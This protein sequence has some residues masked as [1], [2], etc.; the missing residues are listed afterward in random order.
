MD[1]DGLPIVGPGIDFT[2][3][4][5]IQHKR[6]VAFLNHFIAHTASF[7]N[8]FSTVCEEK[9]E[10]MT[11][12]L[13][14]LEITCTIL[15]E[16]LDSIPG[17]KEEIVTVDPYVS[18]TQMPKPREKKTT[19]AAASAPAAPAAPAADAADAAP[20]PPAASVAP[21]PPGAA[22]APPP[23]PPPPPPPAPGAPPPPPPPAAAPPPPGMDTSAPPAPPAPPGAP[24]LPDVGGVPAA[25]AVAED[26]AYAKYRKMANMG[27]PLQA[28]KLKCQ[29][30]GLDPDVL[31]SPAGGG[32]TVPAPPG[33]PPVALPSVSAAPPGP[34]M[35]PPMPPA[36][37]AAPPVPGAG[38]DSDSDLDFDSDS[39]D[40]SK[41]PGPPGPPPG[42]MPIPPPPG[43]GKGSDDDFSDDAS[44]N[45]DFDTDSD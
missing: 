37:A 11:V 16:K 10:K 33:I 26:P 35:P 7:L 13:Q 42:G 21:P 14:R 45:D 8:R 5:P 41:P 9:L 23:P 1:A 44:S 18:T 2:N 39:D 32:A 34:P 28:V 20:A 12:R 29:A 31:D 22:T 38:A 43:G 36:A 40:D 27:I 4:K 15:E 30:D 17:L 19:E 24:G 3:V 6:T 25:P